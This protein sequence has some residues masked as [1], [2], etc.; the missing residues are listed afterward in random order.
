MCSMVGGIG[1]FCCSSL[2]PRFV[3]G[4]VDCLSERLEQKRRQKLGRRSILS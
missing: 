1:G 3:H 2:L 4:A